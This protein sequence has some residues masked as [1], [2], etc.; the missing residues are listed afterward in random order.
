MRIELEYQFNA[1]FK[2]L[3]PYP[4]RFRDEIKE[5]RKGAKGAPSAPR[6][7]LESGLNLPQN[8]LPVFV[9]LLRLGGLAGI[10]F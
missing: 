9:R 1:S 10:F 7:N 8:I 4:L 6:K 2:I 5:N 3:Q